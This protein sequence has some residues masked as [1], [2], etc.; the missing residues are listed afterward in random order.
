MNNRV[1]KTIY[2]NC[3]KIIQNKKLLLIPPININ[4]TQTFLKCDAIQTK[5]LLISTLPSNIQTSNS[6]NNYYNK[7]LESRLDSKLLKEIIKTE[8][9]DEKNKNIDGFE[10][11]RYLNSL[12]YVNKKSNITN[13]NGIKIITT[14]LFDQEISK[15]ENGNFYHY[16]IIIENNSD[17][18]IQLLGRKW[19]FSSES[20]EGDDSWSLNVPSLNSGINFAPVRRNI[21]FTLLLY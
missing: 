20:E 19:I 11:I 8:F 5:Q 3:L 7:Y 10:S 9:H 1:N 13:K 6:I 12:I 15:G 18:R 4:E 2:K 17:K 14:G 16:R 21:Y